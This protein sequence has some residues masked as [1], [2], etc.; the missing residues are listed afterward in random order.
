MNEASQLEK[1]KSWIID[2]TYIKSKPEKMLN[3][4]SILNLTSLLLII[5]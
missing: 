3:L 1:W 4:I 5:R 2:A